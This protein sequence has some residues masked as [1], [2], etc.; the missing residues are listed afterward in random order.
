MIRRNR[1]LVLLVVLLVVAAG[2]VVVKDIP[3]YT[4]WGGNPAREIR[5]L[6][7]HETYHQS[8]EKQHRIVSSG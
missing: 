8:L 6:M 2:S 4:L 5:K 7:G 1:T 3:P